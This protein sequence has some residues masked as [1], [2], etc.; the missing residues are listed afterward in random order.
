ME[1][2]WTVSARALEDQIPRAT[3]RFTLTYQFLPTLS[4]GIE[5]NPQVEEV[6]P[7]LNWLVLQ[8]K[9]KR[10]AIVIGTSSDRIGTPEGQ[11]YYLTV[12]KNLKGLTHLPIAPYIGAAYGTFEDRWRFIGGMEI[13]FTHGFWALV[14]YDGVNWHPTVNYS[15]GRHTGTFLMVD[16][17]DPGVAYSIR[18]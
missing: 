5:Y 4:A 15:Y 6:N 18:F 3:Y 10:P 14:I 9:D 2:R 16:G 13:D 17:E 1:D 12:S 8:E 11:S 7:L